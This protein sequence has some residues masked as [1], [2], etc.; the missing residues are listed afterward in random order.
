LLE[1][2]LRF[3]GLEQL[4]VRLRQRVV[5]LDACFARE[6]FMAATKDG[7]VFVNVGTIDRLAP[8]PAAV[9]RLA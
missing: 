2:G 7:E 6:N 1:V 9:R 8:A 5:G 4:R 3:R